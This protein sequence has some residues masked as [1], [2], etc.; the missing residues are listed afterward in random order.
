MALIIEWMDRGWNKGAQKAK[1]DIDELKKKARELARD[2]A[3]GTAAFVG[4]TAAFFKF[5]EMG[6]KV[7]NV[8]DTFEKVRIQ[9]GLLPG[10]LKEIQE[11]TEG[12]VTDMKLMA[13]TG[14][15][16]SD[17]LDPAKLI[18]L[19]KMAHQISEVSGAD[20]VDVFQAMQISMSKLNTVSLTGVGITIRADEAFDRYA[21]TIGKTAAQL[22]YHEKQMAIYVELQDKYRTKFLSLGD[23]SSGLKQQYEQLSTGVQNLKDK[24]FRMLAE[25][26]AIEKFFG[27]LIS[28]V[29]AMSTALDNAGPKIEAAT[30][31]II[32]LYKGLV[33]FA[34]GTVKPALENIW[35]FR[36]AIAALAAVVGT[37]IVASKIMGIGV[38]LG[39]V[40]GVAASAVIALA[41]SFA[42]LG[43]LM[44]S[45]MKKSDQ[46]AQE[47]TGSLRAQ[48]LVLKQFERMNWYGLDIPPWNK[49][50]NRIA[51]IEQM[52]AG[53][54]GT[55]N[56]LAGM[57]ANIP[58]TLGQAGNLKMG[59]SGGEGVGGG[60]GPAALKVTEDGL[61]QAEIIH[62]DFNSKLLDITSRRVDGEVELVNRGAV[63]EVRAMQM[64]QALYER[65]FAAMGTYSYKFFDD[66]SRRG[67]T[68]NAM[69]IKGFGE[70]AASYIEAKAKQ[71]GIDAL[72]F[73][74]QGIVSLARGNLGAAAAFGVAAA[75]AGALAGIGYVM[76][77]GIRYESQQRA[78]SISAEQEDQWN[79]E[80]GVG[81]SA[82]AT[83]ARRQATGVVNTRPISINVYSSSYFQSG[84]MI[85]GDSE[86]A[87][88][89]LYERI[90]R[91]RIE[92]DIESGMIAIPA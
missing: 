46:G 64:R 15:A 25:S 68:L 53:I 4:F 62:Q 40:T 41:S 87:A 81:A 65:G 30:E 32:G 54:K 38:A 47:L 26:P 16:L 75:K 23:V 56:L 90:T 33:N 84:Y 20:I 63:A 58:G 21:L 69:L 12:T 14:R 77:G 28:K 27:I 11:A 60:A 18:E 67:R 88:N 71:A 3:V 49:I 83:A 35:K 1:L 13:S 37:G 57:G 22:T 86:T 45:E 34:S 72:E 89:D 50:K 59:A 8:T 24:F 2:L 36:D 55:G 42:G 9:A 61:K 70:V 85:F 39:L 17:G 6:A 66:A 91:E 29:G 78:N 31:K 73:A 82:T 10:V 44:Y 80:T 76:S 48:H 79:R 52:N 43:T 92:N 19:W 7:K 51:D 5:I 74:Y